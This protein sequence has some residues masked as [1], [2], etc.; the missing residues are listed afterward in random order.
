MCYITATEFKKNL[1]HYMEL[2][3][4][5]DIYVTK[6]NKVITVLTSPAK[7]AFDKFLSYQGALYSKDKEGETI[8]D[9]LVEELENH[10]NPR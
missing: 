9:M 3:H 1:G 4:A 10:A 2:S 7:V 5:E 6:N 8:E